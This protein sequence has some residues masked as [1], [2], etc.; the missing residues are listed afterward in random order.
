MIEIL[1]FVAWT[2]FCC[3]TGIFVGYFMKKEEMTF[4]GSYYLSEDKRF[5]KAGEF[6]RYVNDVEIFPI[7]IYTN[8][9][10]RSSFINTKNDS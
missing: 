3:F 6:R 9:Q 8:Y 10:K 1:I 2:V 4:I 7:E 5:D